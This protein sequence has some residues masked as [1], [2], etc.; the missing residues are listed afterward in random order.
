M[1]MTPQSTGNMPYNPYQPNNSINRLSN[2][3]TENTVFANRK[4]MYRKSQYPQENPN[5]SNMDQSEMQPV[6]QQ[7]QP[8]QMRR[9]PPMTPTAYNNQ[10]YAQMQ[11]AM[12]QRRRYNQVR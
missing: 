8:D 2:Y 5:Y 10:Q 4:K 9:M 3:P 6:S 7:A 1:P 11:N 12:N